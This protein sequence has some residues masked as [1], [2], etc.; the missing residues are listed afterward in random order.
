MRREDDA[1][2]VGEETACN[3]AGSVGCED[4]AGVILED[5]ACR[6]S[7]GVRSED[8]GSSVEEET[9]ADMSGA[10]DAEAVLENAAG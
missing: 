10:N 1:D 7:D 5:A 9:R 2:I 8:D 3:T 6:A 4:D